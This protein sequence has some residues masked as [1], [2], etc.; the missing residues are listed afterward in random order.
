MLEA[1]AK[2]CPRAM[3]NLRAKTS[4]ES[5]RFEDFALAGVIIW[6]E[7]AN[8]RPSREGLD[9]RSEHFLKTASCDKQA[10]RQRGR[11][12]G[13]KDLQA[14]PNKDQQSKVPPC[15]EIMTNCELGYACMSFFCYPQAC[16]CLPTVFSDFGKL[17]CRLHEPDAEGLFPGCTTA[18][19]GIIRWHFATAALQR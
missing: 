15:S 10:R 5:I 11:S 7:L 4:T 13:S 3:Q 6:A 19:S 8:C 12:Q 2:G 14:V 9:C 1:S 18:R 16:V 17:I